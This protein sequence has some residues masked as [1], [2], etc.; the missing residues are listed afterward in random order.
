MDLAPYETR[1]MY[2]R[3]GWV[4]DHA[5]AP[6]RFGLETW[7]QRDICDR[8][9]YPFRDDEIDFVVCSHTLEDVRDPVW[10]CAEMAR[11][12]RAGY[13]EVPSRLEEQ[14]YGV[15]GPF[16][17]WYHH[18][19]LVDVADGRIEFIFKPHGMHLREENYFPREFGP[20]LTPEERVQSLWWEGGFEYRER[21]FADQE[22]FFDYL[23]EFVEQTRR[24]RP[25]PQAGSVRRALRRALAQARRL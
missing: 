14:T 6:E 18:R 24:E 21:F 4:H 15:A 8:E 23:G 22:S 13:I 2:G 11:I 7:I 16:V 12:G 9:P 25:V 19:W 5:P 10:V 20:A 17:G 1:G 3:H